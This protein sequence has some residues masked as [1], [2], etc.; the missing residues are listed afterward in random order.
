MGTEATVIGNGPSLA[1]VDLFALP[2]KTYACN[3]VHLHP[4]WKAGWR[5][6][7]YICGDMSLNPNYLEDMRYHLQGDYPVVVMDVF[8]PELGPWAEYPQVR[9]IPRCGHGSPYDNLPRS[10]HLPTYCWF[11]K[12][13]NVA[14]QLA[15]VEQGAAR[16][17]YVGCDMG[18]NKTG[19]N[20]FV[21]DYLPEGTYQEASRADVRNDTL[22]MMHAILG[23]EL[24]KRGIP[25]ELIS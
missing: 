6:D 24:E 12:A 2:G 11:G 1:H 25:Y 7:F 18:F 20:Y 19:L 9:V 8:Y 14:T 13:V 5:P 4:S 22:R 3:R 10:W 21:A 15:V 17:S 16:V 23:W